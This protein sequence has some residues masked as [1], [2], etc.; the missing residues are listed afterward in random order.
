M[1]MPVDMIVGFAKLFN[2][3][4]VSFS[5]GSTEQLPE[6]VK[7]VIGKEMNEV[8]KL[9]K[10]RGKEWK[11]SDKEVWEGFFNSMAGTANVYFVIPTC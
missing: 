1:G 6:S 9:A 4:D 3:L 5:F 2:S 8:G 7:E 10:P 11:E